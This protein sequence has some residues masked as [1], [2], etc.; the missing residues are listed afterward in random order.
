VIGLRDTLRERTQDLHGTLDSSLPLLSPALT[1]EQYVAFLGRMYAWL[2]PTERM[3]QD[4]LA[5][6]RFRVRPLRRAPA[7]VADLADLGGRP[8]V[9]DRSIPRLESEAHAVGCCYVL[10]GS[11]LGGQL[12]AR[13]LS[14]T[15]NLSTERGSR[16]FRGSGADTGQ[17][18]RDVCRALDEYPTISS[19]PIVD[20]ARRTFQSLI[21][22]LT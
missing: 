7:I 16:Y 11:A 13:H 4:L 9:L 14:R 21:A 12:I 10:E 22:W 20:G 18:W 6:G 3:T 8:A 15:L 2:E 19:E 1:L 5:D 17:R